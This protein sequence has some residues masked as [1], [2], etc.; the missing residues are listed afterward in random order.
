MQSINIDTIGQVFPILAGLKA[1][2]DLVMGIYRGNTQIFNASVSQG[3]Y[4]TM[5]FNDNPPAGSYTYS[6]RIYTV[7]TDPTVR[8]RF[9]MIFELKR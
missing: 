3:T 7:N 6:I 4:Q 1:H 9:L 2:D 8:K 5:A